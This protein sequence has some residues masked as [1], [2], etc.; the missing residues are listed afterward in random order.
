MC[1][2]R[3]SIHMQFCCK[4]KKRFLNE[5]VMDFWIDFYFLPSNLLLFHIGSSIPQIIS[6]NVRQGQKKVINPPFFTPYALSPLLFFFFLLLLLLL[7]LQPYQNVK[8]ENRKRTINGRC[9]WWRCGL[10]MPA[11]VWWLV[12]ARQ[13]LSVDM[14]RKAVAATDTKG[15]LCW[16]PIQVVIV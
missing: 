8:C 1:L 2:T 10:I 15:A 6:L 14:C 7:L 9:A 16:V 11:I 3:N 5:E 12:R 4:Q 13:P